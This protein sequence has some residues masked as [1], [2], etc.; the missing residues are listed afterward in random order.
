M[1]FRLQQ[2][3]MTVND[4]ERQSIYCFLDSGVRIATKRLRQELRG[5]HYKVHY[6]QLS[7][8]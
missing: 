2:K 7:A 3:S 4:D 8:Y 6:T 5:F 1:G